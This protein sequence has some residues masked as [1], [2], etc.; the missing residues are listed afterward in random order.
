MRIA[1][2]VH[3]FEAGGVER[4]ALRLANEW[5]A[6]G[7]QVIVVLGR[8]RG[9]CRLSAPPLDYWSLREPVAT[10]RWETL[11][12]IWSM[13]QFL[14]RDRADV[15]FCPGNTYTVV[16]VAMKLL[17][18]IRCPP[19]A[20]KISNDLHRR[21]IPAP[22]RPFYRWWLRVQGTTLDRFVAIAPPMRAEVVAELCI[23]E[24]QA[25]VIPDPALSDADIQAFAECRAA[26]ARWNGCRYLAI[27]RLV[28]QKNL[29]LLLEA[30]ARHSQPEDH[31][32]VA[33]AGPEFDRLS[34]YIAE[35]GLS[36]RITLCGHVEDTVSLFGAADVM[37]LSS[38]YEGVPA[39]ILEALAAGVPMA[40]TDCCT[41]M[42]WLTGNGAFG[43]I[44][45]CGDVDALGKA[46]LRAKRLAPDRDAMRRFAADFTLTRSSRKYIAGFEQLTKDWRARALDRMQHG[47]WLQRV[48]DA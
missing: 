38:I 42:R 34:G 26:D 17:L 24:S 2:P 31:L 27:G 32:T 39:V 11:W 6:Q 7:H 15:I 22:F 23:A 14:L 43:A 4:V 44:A 45:P 48:F 25:L 16:C 9:T 36:S 40:V 3:S 35:H 5:Q 12:M 18:G 46:M 13:L 33:G 47:R 19:V 30:F 37:V 41:S 8:D 10:D 29:P 21:D 20:V 28:P 1:I